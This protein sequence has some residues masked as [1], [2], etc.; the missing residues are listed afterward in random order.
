MNFA[1]NYRGYQMS[2]PVNEL[3]YVVKQNRRWDNHVE[4]LHPTLMQVNR[5]VFNHNRSLIFPAGNEYRRFEILSEYVPTMRGDRMEYDDTYYH[6]LLYADEQRT[7]Y[8]YDEDQN[9]R[10]YVRNGENVTN[11]TAVSYTHLTLPTILLV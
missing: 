6:A 9:G 2:N 5:L 1:V 3:K 7:M 11:D 4:D 10:Y 8:V